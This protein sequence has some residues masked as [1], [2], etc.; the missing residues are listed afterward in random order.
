M[1][2]KESLKR[3]LTNILNNMSRCTLDNNE[4]NSTINFEVLRFSDQKKRPDTPQVT[5]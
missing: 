2:V 1:V 5:G 4:I 3:N